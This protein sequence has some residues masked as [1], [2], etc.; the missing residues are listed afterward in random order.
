MWDMQ[1]LGVDLYHVVFWLFLYSFMGWIW[2]SS[3]VS[4]KEKHLV[5]RGFVTGPVCTI[6]GIGAVSVYLILRP[7]EGHG[8]WLFLGGILL[9]TVLEYF[10][11]WFMETLFHTIWWDY[12]KER[13][14][15]HGRICLKSSI[16]WGFFTLLM[17]EVLQPFA[18]WVVGL[19]PEKVGHMIVILSVCLYAV[20]FLISVL[21][22]ASLG[23]KLAKLSGI[24]EDFT[25]YVQKTRAY[26][27]AE[28][29][30]DTL[31]SYRKLLNL[32]EVHDR[33]EE[34]QEVILG[35]MEE[36][37]LGSHMTGVKLK[38][39]HFYEQYQESVS[40]ITG[41]NRRF[42]KAYPNLHKAHRNRKKGK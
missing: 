10:T 28:E 37:G 13:F 17:F 20:D 8:L 33:L 38:F 22:A 40:R 15:L 30:K 42:L 23:E 3:Y 2:E 31:E 21:A 6:Y 25:E 7:L 9:A 34:Y 26:E 4:I 11:A 12:S 41:V 18:A 32:R 27:S 16:A 19:L 14:N 39:K 24:L 29:W 36:K 35:K 1:I 5:N